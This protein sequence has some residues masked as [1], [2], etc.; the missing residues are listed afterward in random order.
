[1][2]SD[3]KPFSALTCGV[4]VIKIPGRHFEKWKLKIP[5]PEMGRPPIVSPGVREILARRAVESAMWGHLLKQNFQA[6]VADANCE[7]GH[8]G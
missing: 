7:R 1:M 3:L 8:G 5:R 2:F 6:R 4:T